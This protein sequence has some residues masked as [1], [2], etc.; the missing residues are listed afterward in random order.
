MLLSYHFILNELQQLP[1]DEQVLDSICY[2]TMFFCRTLASFFY[3][4]VNVLFSLPA[5][6]HT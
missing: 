5:F 3:L 2:G 4:S 1:C 6:N